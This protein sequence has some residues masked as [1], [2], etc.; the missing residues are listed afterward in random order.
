[1][2]NTAIDSKKI[3]S[4]DSLFAYLKK[5]I[6]YRLSHQ[7]SKGQMDIPKLDLS[8]NESHLAQFIIDNKLSDDETV[9]LLLAIIP[10]I[11]PQFLSKVLIDIFP[12]GENLSEFGGTK[13]KNHKGILPTGETAMFVLA[14]FDL[15]KRLELMEMMM[16]ES[17]LFKNDIL[18]LD[19]IPNGEPRMSGKLCIAEEYVLKLT[20]G[21]IIQ[22]Q[23]GFD[24]PARLLETA[25]KWEDLVLK[26]KTMEDIKEIENWLN[27][28]SVLINDWNMK[29]KIKPG[30]RALFHGPPGTG[31]TLTASLLGKYSKNDIYHIDL[32]LIV[33]KYIGETE[34]NLSNLFN[35]AA[36]KGW[37]LFFDEADA[38]F[39]RRTSLSD[40]HD[41]YANQEVSYLLQR[42]ETYSGLVILAF[43]N[44]KSINASFA[45]RFQSIIE[46]ELPNYNERLRLWHNYLP[47]KKA[48]LDK[49]VIVKD[50]AKEYALTGA[51]IVN[52]TQFS[53]LK[54]ISDGQNKVT[55]T[56][57]LEGVHREL[58]K[59]E[60]YH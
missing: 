24:F 3:S 20:S 35:N 19:N 31:K 36:N 43:N 5:R 41:K 27:Y 18:Y 44:K 37:I 60:K 33:S 59:K 23:L 16:W 15:A 50:L 25:L 9:C 7:S 11:A 57:I 32:S 14:G 52:V 21:R 45:R 2:K 13:G 38:L 26:D 55:N 17:D 29:D 6:E 42:I 54:A 39:G 46:F 40:A 28:N 8:N 4:L 48:S 22:P 1:M 12:S 30:F 53:S 51:N 47:K 10:H 58:L 49:K 56:Y 34:K